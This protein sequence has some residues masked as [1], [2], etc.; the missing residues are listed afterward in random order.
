MSDRATARRTRF[1][2]SVAVVTGAGSGIGRALV[3]GLLAEGA[4]VVANDLDVTSLAALGDDRLALVEG[5]VSLDSTVAAIAAAVAATEQGVAAALF[6][7]AGIASTTPALEMTSAEWSRVMGVNVDAVFRLSVALGR[8][9]IAAGRGAIV[10]TASIAGTHGLP[11][12]S[13]YVVSKHALVGLTRALAVEWGPHGVRVNAFCPGLT[14][15]PINATLRAKA[16]DYWAARE[17]AV[18]L[19]RAGSAAEQAAFAL[20]LASD[21]ASYATG[22]VVEI[23]GGGHTLHSGYTVE[24]PPIASD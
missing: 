23:D 22:L 24:R 6:N 14:E 19:R 8:G 5:D 11:D 2:G 12:R 10:N 4:F 18:P 17:R 21:D 13:A 9:M 3:E 7:N 1:D 20:H 16:P 15:T